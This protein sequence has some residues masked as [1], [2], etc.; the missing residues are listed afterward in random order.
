MKFFVSLFILTG[1]ILRW[2][3]VKIKNNSFIW[4]SRSICFLVPF[5]RS[6]WIKK[7]GN[8]GRDLY[9]L[10]DQGIL[11]RLIYHLDKNIQSYGS[12]FTSSIRYFKTPKGKYYTRGMLGLCVFIGV[13]T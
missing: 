12:M 4:F 7:F 5:N 1:V 3:D 6:F 11:R 9:Y 10:L 2:K 13:L 8:R